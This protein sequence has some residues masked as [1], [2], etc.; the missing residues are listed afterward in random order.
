[1]LC[2]C[3][4]CAWVKHNKGNTSYLLLALSPR[5]SQ[6]DPPRPETWQEKRKNTQKTPA[7]VSILQRK[8]HNF[9]DTAV[10]QTSYS[11]PWISSLSSETRNSNANF[12]LATETIWTPFKNLIN[13]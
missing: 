1:M 5:L 8:G 2:W 11:R 3:M 7:L 10:E 12:P 9:N 4:L 13:I 6:L